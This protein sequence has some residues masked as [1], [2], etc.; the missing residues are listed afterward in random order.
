V[1]SVQSNHLSYGD[2]LPGGQVNISGGYIVLAPGSV[3]DVS[4]AAGLSTLQSAGSGQADLIAAL[5]HR[6]MF[7][8]ASAGGTISISANLG[9][10]LEGTL[11]GK[12]GGAN[13]A[14]G[15]LNLTLSGHGAALVDDAYVPSGDWPAIE[16]TY[17]VLEPTVAP[18]YLSNA[19][20]GTPGTDLGLFG[21]SGTNLA[22]LPRVDAYMPVSVQMVQNGGFASLSLSAPP[23]LQTPDPL[24]NSGYGYVTFSGSTSLT[25]PGQLTLN[26]GT[27]IVPNN[28]TQTLAANYIQW[29]NTAGGSVQPGASAGT[30]TLNIVANTVDLI[31]NLAVQ[32]AKT[33]SLT[34]SGDLRLTGV[35]P[36]IVPTT[37]PQ[38]QGTLVS[39]GELDFHRYR[40]HAELGDQNRLHRERRSAHCTAFGRRGA[41]RPCSRHRAGRDAGRAY[42]Q[43][44]SGRDRPERHH[45]ACLH[46]FRR[47]VQP[48]CD[49]PRRARRVELC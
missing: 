1:T 18:F 21:A 32:G 37:L 5:S 20:I 6:R 10:I 11:L 3:I 26:T 15:T 28:T 4:G 43:H 40:I 48:E 34:V 33:T 30:G 39:A 42:G 22:N 14:G 38:L 45:D 47:P 24:T 12:S 31:G 35:L 16:N 13:A 19:Q 36:A 2:V 7:P 41:E 44:Q 17:T 25:L 9:A 23:G 8:A 46:Q 27:I 29:D 49:S